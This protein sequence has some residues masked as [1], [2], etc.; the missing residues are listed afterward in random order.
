[1]SCSAGSMPEAFAAIMATHMMLCPQCRRDLALMEHIGT[2]LFDQLAPASIE[3]AAPVAQ[4]RSLEAE[5][6]TQPASH[7]KS[8]AM[9]GDVPATLAPVLGTSLDS[10]PWKRLGPGLWQHR[11]ALSNE[12]RGDLRLFKVAPGKALPEHGHSGMEL[13]LV[14]RGAF[15]DAT[16]EYKVGD[17]AD[18]DDAVTHQPVADDKE[19]C[20]C[21]AAT[22]GRLKF[23]GKLARL[24]QPLTGL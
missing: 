11:I 12:Q 7:S 13:T 3:R 21:L 20:I 16:G 23:K 8:T 4:L 24:I 22:L 17:V 2:A 14:L 1:M 9:A 5:T 10:I 19:G 6:P 18:V 15:R